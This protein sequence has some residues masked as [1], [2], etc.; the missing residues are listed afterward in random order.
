MKTIS[1]LLV[2]S[3]LLGAVAPNGVYARVRTEGRSVESR[4]STARL[5]EVFDK[6]QYDISVVWDQTD[7]QFKNEVERELKE[8]I[9][10]L[11]AE[12][13][14]NEEIISFMENKILDDQA[15]TEFRE[16]LNVMQIQ[17]LSQEQILGEVMRFVDKSY[18]QGASFS[19]G[20]R[21]T[22]VGVL[23]VA[24]FVGIVAVIIISHKKDKNPGCKSNCSPD[25]GNNNHGNNGH[26]NND[27]GVDV[28]NP[29]HGHGG[30]NGENDP[31]GPID[32]ESHGTHHGHGH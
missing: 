19:G 20:R 2:T 32:D 31:S 12:G 14:T 17:N 24:I 30:P 9:Q 25:D 1:N 11:T 7:F 21:H 28:S 13:L 27:D 29:G 3:F 10:R 15:K 6:Y 16:L 8:S 4:D 22:Y 26:G 23:A 18:Q 5:S